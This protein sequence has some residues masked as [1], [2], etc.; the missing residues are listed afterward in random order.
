MCKNAGAAGCVFTHVLSGKQT[1]KRT[2]RRRASGTDNE[3]R[4]RLIGAADMKRLRH[5]YSRM[6]LVQ[7]VLYS[8]IFPQEIIFVVFRVFQF[9]QYTRQHPAPH[10]CPFH[11]EVPV[12]R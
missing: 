1:K 9:I 11:G 10:V 8:C 2:G 4:I 7:Q 12:Q 6:V 5:F 3:Y